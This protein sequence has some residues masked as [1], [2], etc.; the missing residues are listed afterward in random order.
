MALAARFVLRALEGL[1][2]GRLT[3]TLPDGSVRRFGA[4]E[5]PA[6]ELHI[7]DGRFFRRVLI[8]GAIGFAEAYLDGTWQTPDL[9]GL[10]A[11]LAANERALGGLGRTNVLGGLLLKLMHRLRANSRRGARRNIHAHYDLGNEFYGLW[12][13]GS[14]TYSAG[15]YDGDRERPLEAAQAAKYERVLA[16]LGARQGDSLLEI[17]CGWGAFAELAARRGLRVTGVTISRQQLDFAAARLQAAGLSDR[18][19]LQFRDYRDIEGRYDHVVS[20]EMVEAVGERYWPDYFAA[21]KRLLAPRGSALIQAIVMADGLFEAY[22]RNPDFIQSYVFPG[23]MLLS[24]GALRQQCRAAGLRVGELYSF[25]LD[26]ART[27]EAW[28][29]RFDRA[30]GQIAKLGFDPRFCRMWRYYLAYCAAGFATG[31]TDVLQ[32]HLRPI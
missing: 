12:L 22:R 29:E 15:L 17:G 2:M 27:L 23:G 30:V 31:R 8:D 13:D 18:V 1:A 24:P 9:P 19:E 5:A 20:I 28:L 16:Q 25:G 11:L 10:I 14:M 6:A 21:L 7:K 32:A 26:Y 3:V 4:A